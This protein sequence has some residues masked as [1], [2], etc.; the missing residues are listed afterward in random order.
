MGFTSEHPT[1]GE[2]F[3]YVSHLPRFPTEPDHPPAVSLS[4]TALTDV[5]PARFC[6]RPNLSLIKL[7]LILLAAHGS[8]M[9][10]SQS[11]LLNGID[12]IVDIGGA[13]AP[14]DL[15]RNASGST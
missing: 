2:A 5:P 10:V 4:C 3:A 1:R 11:G 9:Q 13:E 7:P 6:L 14:P 8:T 15:G 12:R